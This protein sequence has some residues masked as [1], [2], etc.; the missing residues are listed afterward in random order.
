MEPSAEGLQL[1]ET[2]LKKLQPSL[3]RPMSPMS[4]SSGEDEVVADLAKP[5]RIAR[6]KSWVYNAMQTLVGLGSEG[7]GVVEA[8]ELYVAG[9][10][11]VRLRGAD[12]KTAGTRK[13]MCPAEDGE[14]DAG[15]DMV[16]PDLSD[17][18]YWETK[19]RY[20]EARCQP[21]CQERRKRRRLEPAAEEQEKKTA[22]VA[23]A[24]EEAEGAR[25]E[26][27]RIEESRLLWRD[28]QDAIDVWIRGL[29]PIERPR[30]F[31]P[32]PDDSHS[33]PT[34]RS[35]YDSSHSKDTNKPPSSDSSIIEITST[36]FS[37]AVGGRQRA[38]DAPDASMTAVAG[39]ATQNNNT[40]ER[41][42]A[43]GTTTLWKKE[44]G[45]YRGVTHLTSPPESQGAT[46]T[47]DK[48]FKGLGKRRRSEGQVAQWGG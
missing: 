18:E 14:V 11:D 47:L 45:E 39:T 12:S 21:L 23:A 35:S 28:K 43:L 38:P 4:I 25:A 3:I 34:S 17:A 2:N 32:I 10:G 44:D 8:D 7:R 19:L 5:E 41:A 29:P 46:N 33:S 1:T 27:L 31:S 15:A 13:R 20:L 16:Q 36:Q 24:A 26:C 22:A 37:H 48:A 9:P 42:V 40:Q 6:L 30:Q